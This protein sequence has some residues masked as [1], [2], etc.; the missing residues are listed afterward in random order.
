MARLAI[1]L[2]IVAQ[3]LAQR[4]LADDRDAVD[5]CAGRRYDYV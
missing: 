5:A 1:G 2:P 3:L 4:Q